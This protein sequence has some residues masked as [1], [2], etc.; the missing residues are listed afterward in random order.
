LAE[1]MNGRTKWQIIFN[2]K[3]EH[4]LIQYIDTDNKI[5][6]SKMTFPPSL[7]RLM[8]SAL[9]RAEKSGLIKYGYA[10]CIVE[11]EIVNS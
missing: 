7:M 3:I 5:L 9:R 10:P 8:R 1:E 11:D 4:F 2:P 6:S